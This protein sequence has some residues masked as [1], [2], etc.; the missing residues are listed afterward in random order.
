[1]YGCGTRL[2]ELLSPIIPHHGP[3]RALAFS[4]DGQLLA[5][6]DDNSGR[7]SSP[8]GDAAPGRYLT[9]HLGLSLVP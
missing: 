2:P 9:G 7:L 8:T 5:T 3:V 1:M 6:G 4:P